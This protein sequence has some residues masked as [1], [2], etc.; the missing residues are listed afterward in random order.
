MSKD[1]PAFSLQEQ[2]VVYLGLEGEEGS[3]GGRQFIDRM[4]FGSVIKLTNVGGEDSLGAGLPEMSQL[5]SGE[6]I[7]FEKKAREINLVRNGW[8]AASHRIALGIPLHPDQMTE[9]D[10]VALPGIGNVLAER[11]ELNRQENGDFGSLSALLRIKGIGMKS[12]EKW[13][14]FF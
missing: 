8:I 5:V 3:F 12:I 7:S 10:W 11:I 2:D 6:I 9:E 1:L 13:R 14:D 4:A